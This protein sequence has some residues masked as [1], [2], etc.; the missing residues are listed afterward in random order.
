MD[1]PATVIGVYGLATGSH[2]PCG[3]DAVNTAAK[4][5]LVELDL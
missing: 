5:E 3:H 2:L 4:N 1:I